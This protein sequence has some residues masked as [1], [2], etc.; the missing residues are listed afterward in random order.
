MIFLFCVHQVRR[1]ASHP[2]V[3]IWSGNNENEAALATDWFNIPASQR[4][5]YVK[6]YVTLYVDNIRAIVQQVTDESHAEF[7][8]RV[9]VCSVHSDVCDVSFRRT[10]LAP[11][12]SPAP[13]TGLSRSRK[14]G[15]HR[16]RTT[17]CTGTHISTATSR[18]AGTG[19]LSLGHAS[20]PNTASSR[21]R[22]SPHCSR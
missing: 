17:R 10:R 14:D 12:S 21:G 16:T 20:P 9:D 6:D 22:P 4:P 8:T 11:S 2:S 5:T 13:Q 19:G 7:Q 3:I 1:L 18:T 15:W